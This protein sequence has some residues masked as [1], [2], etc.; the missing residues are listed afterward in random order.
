MDL[1]NSMGGRTTSKASIQ[2]ALGVSPTTYTEYVAVLANTIVH[3]E[4]DQKHAL[5][6]M[7]A[8]TTARDNMLHYVEARKYDET[9]MKLSVNDNFARSSHH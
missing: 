2:D 1:T 8:A 9:P 6:T 3:L 4:R 7:I 5:E